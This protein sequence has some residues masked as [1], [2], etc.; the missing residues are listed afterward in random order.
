MSA[1]VSGKKV[2]LS[3]ARM[4]LTRTIG[5]PVLLYVIISVEITALT[6]LGIDT[7]ALSVWLASSII[8]LLILLL[9]A[10]RAK[11]RSLKDGLILGV[12]WAA[13]C[14]ILDAVVIIV[15]FNQP[16]YFEQPQ[17]W[18]SY[19]LAFIIPAIYGYRVNNARV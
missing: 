5:Y 8:V 13:I 6:L 14:L 17:S 16:S 10:R 9:L 12:A 3:H 19:I 2:Y 18:L 11:I 7:N 15:L 1:G 4:N